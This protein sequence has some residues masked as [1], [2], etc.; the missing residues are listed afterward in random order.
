MLAAVD[1]ADGV[2]WAVGTTNDG[3]ASRTLILRTFSP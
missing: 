2:G 1:V 3:S